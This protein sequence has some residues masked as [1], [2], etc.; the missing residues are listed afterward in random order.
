MSEGDLEKKILD[1]ANYWASHEVFD[2]ETRQEVAQL[3]ESRDMVSLRERFET[4]LEFGTAGLRGVMGPGT[5][6]MN[7]Y[8]VAKATFALGKYLKDFRPGAQT[9]VAITFDSRRNSEHF[10]QVT[11]EVLC[12]QGHQVWLTRQLRPVPLLSF[13]VREGGCDAG[14]CLTASHNPPDYNG[15]KVYWKNGGQIIP[16]HDEEILARYHALTRYE[17][18][19]RLPFQQALR[20]R[21]VEWIGEEWDEK[22]LNEIAKLRFRDEGKKQVS[23]V[24]TPLHGTGKYLVPQA[25]A[26]FGFDDVTVVPSQG[27]PDGT[28]PTVAF[29]NPEDPAALELAVNL[30]KEKGAP[31]VVATDP[32]ADRLGMVV[33]EEEGYVFLSGNE[34]GSLLTD[35]VL[36]AMSSVGRLP[37]NPLV[38][39]T[40]VTTDLESEI[41]KF[42]G[43]HLDE[44]LTGFKW[45]CEAIEAHDRGERRLRRN[46][47]CGGEEA[48]GFLA[49]NH[50]RDKDGVLACCIAAEMFAHHLSRGVSMKGRLRE[51]YRRHGVFRDQVKAITLR[52]NE[53]SQRIREVMSALR[54]QAPTE[55]GGLTVVRS[56]D[57]LSLKET[58]S[59]GGSRP[60]DFPQSNVLQFWLQDGSKISVRP[61]G[62]EP[63]IKFYLSVRESV[64]REAT[65]DVLDSALI[66][67]Q[68]RATEMESELLRLTKLS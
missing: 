22:Y 26:R 41:A 36:D 44:T 11:A 45:I 55:L 8:N 53:G 7:E 30:A 34:I 65:D 46:F 49:G 28:F 2:R 64:D 35:Y 21:Q 60:L 42:Y 51:L 10:A 1:R 3:L 20:D 15:Y 16:P 66:Q 39:K 57:Y 56:R 25:L 18:I 58:D 17:E 13:L 47:V 6:R 33:K 12:A 43:A 23:V 62:T 68:R 4:E 5:A 29:P 19:P 31:L 32:D 27:E 14:V 40:I 9:K 24:Y 63:K 48:H 61:S 37:E 38:V 67:A 54:N 52:G 59:G 50:A